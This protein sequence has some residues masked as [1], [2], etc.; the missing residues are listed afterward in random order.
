MYWRKSSVLYIHDAMHMY[1]YNAS[2][3]LLNISHIKTL[4]IIY[5]LLTTD[6]YRPLT[7]YAQ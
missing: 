3:I 4:L 2:T 1:G 5:E 7:R 6:T